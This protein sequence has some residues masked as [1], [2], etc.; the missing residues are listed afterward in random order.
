MFGW[1]PS[2]GTLG[3]V[4]AVRTAVS[5]RCQHDCIEPGT[6]TAAGPGARITFD[7]VLFS[8]P[9]LKSF[10]GCKKSALRIASPFQNQAANLPFDT[11]AA[12]SI[13]AP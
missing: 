2:V 3:A 11:Q 6:A 4:G 9:K 7:V 1:L 10:L 12:L 13:I 8:R 5:L